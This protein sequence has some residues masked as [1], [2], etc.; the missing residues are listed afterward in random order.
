MGRARVSAGIC[1]M[2]SE[3]AQNFD[4]ILSPLGAEGG[5][6]DL[7]GEWIKKGRGSRELVQEAVLVSQGQ[8]DGGW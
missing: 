4:F 3:M 8:S 1:E 7:V 6:Q 2:S 5:L